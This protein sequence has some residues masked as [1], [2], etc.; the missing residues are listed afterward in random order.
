[1]NYQYPN[2]TITNK[3]SSI[4]STTYVKGVFWVNGNIQNTGCQTASNIAVFGTFYNS[5][6]ATVAVGYG[7]AVA[8]LSPSGLFKLGAFDFN[9]TGITVSK[10]NH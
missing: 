9:Q 4:G 7:N 1:V 6:G 8:S 3:Q 10:K 2:L 5:T